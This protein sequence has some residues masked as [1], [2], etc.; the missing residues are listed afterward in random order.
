MAYEHKQRMEHRRLEEEASLAEL[1][2]KIEMEY[3]NEGGLT[4]SDASSLDAT[5]FLVDRRPHSTPVTSEKIEA[6]GSHANPG[7]TSTI[8]KETVSQLNPCTE[9]SVTSVSGILKSHDNSTEVILLS[10][11]V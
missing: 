7:A 5:T 1:E 11:R 8:S 3:N 2:W 9:G 6:S 10:D 4:P